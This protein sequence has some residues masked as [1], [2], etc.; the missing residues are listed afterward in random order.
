MMTFATISLLVGMVLGQR[1]KVL[2]LMPT[3]AIALILVIGVGVA[4]ADTVW[5]IVLMAVAAATSLQIGY[6]VGIG[7]RHALVAARAS[8]TPATSITGSTSARRPAH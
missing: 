3:I 8:R 4:R 5:W 1:F 7:I 2:V 6:L